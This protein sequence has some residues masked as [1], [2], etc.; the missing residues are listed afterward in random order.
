MCVEIGCRVA[1]D[2][3]PALERYE[4][5]QKHSS[6]YN[7]AKPQQTQHITKYLSYLSESHH[8]LIGI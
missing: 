3:L 5:N 8:L 7:L 6:Q 2:A 1:E 4:E